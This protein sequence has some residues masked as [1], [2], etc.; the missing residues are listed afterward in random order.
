[1]EAVMVEFDAIL[2]DEIHELPES[3]DGF[4][5][6]TD[7]ELLLNVANTPARNWMI[8][9]GAI[10]IPADSGRLNKW[11]MP[12]NRVMRLLQDPTVKKPEMRPNSR[13]IVKNPKGLRGMVR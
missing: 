11:A 6:V 2:T 1:M 8:R 13:G 10:Q 3:P 7:V 4:A 9:N 12:W 5:F